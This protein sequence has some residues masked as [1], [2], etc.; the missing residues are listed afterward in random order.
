MAPFASK[1]QER[2][3]F[4]NHPEIAKRWAKI[5]DQSSLPEHVK[6]HHRKVIKHMV[7]MAKKNKYSGALLG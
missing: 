2:F 1:A 7:K 6:K 5:T 4:A 3:M